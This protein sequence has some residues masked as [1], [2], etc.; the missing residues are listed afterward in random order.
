MFRQDKLSALAMAFVIIALGLSTTAFAVQK[1]S[2]KSEKSEKKAPKPMP[3]GTPVMWR[4]PADITTRDLLNGSGGEAGKPDLSRVTLIEKV[5]GGFSEK[6][7]VKDAAGREWVAKVSREAQSETA[8]VRL[9]WAVGYATELTYLAPTVTIA[10]TPKGT[11][12]NVRFEGRSKDVKRLDP[13]LWDKNPFSGKRELQGLKVMML[14]LNNWDIKDDNNG[15]LHVVTPDGQSELQYIVSDLGATF[16]KVGSGPL[17][18]LKRSRNNPEDY[19]DSKFIDHVHKDKVFFHYGGK[20]QDIFEDISVGDVQWIAALLSRL[21]DQQLSDAFRA[22]NY[23]AEEVSLLT[24]TVRARI[25]ELVNLP[26]S[27]S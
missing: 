23:N 21:S 14:L 4:E 6:Y 9:L 15:I 3:E 7:R 17:W 2:D 11:Y 8:A 16:G 1:K 13:W 20:K 25:N 18:A 26:P 24:S 5:K 10:G 22:A 12:E 19:A 27:Q